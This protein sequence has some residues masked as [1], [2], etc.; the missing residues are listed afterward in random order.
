MLKTFYSL[1]EADLQA[2]G[3]SSTDTV[4]EY[5]RHFNSVDREIG[6]IE[7]YVDAI[8]QDWSDFR[9]MVGSTALID[10][11]VESVS[12]GAYQVPVNNI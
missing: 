2:E 12:Y 10:A 4:R 7:V 11:V 5:Y 8:E 3:L 6:F 9:V 1:A